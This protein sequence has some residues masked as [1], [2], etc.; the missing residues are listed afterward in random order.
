VYTVQEEN[1]MVEVCARLT[2][3][4]AQ[5]L[6]RPVLDVTVVEDTAMKE[7]GKCLIHV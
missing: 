5:G 7:I 1:E 2:G 6:E 4:I 3:T